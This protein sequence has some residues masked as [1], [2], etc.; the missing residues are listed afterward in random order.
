MRQEGR[1]I[2]LVNKI[3]AYEYRIRDTIT[4]EANEMLGFPADLSGLYN[5]NSDF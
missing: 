5:R 4:V 2:G 3:K 1:G